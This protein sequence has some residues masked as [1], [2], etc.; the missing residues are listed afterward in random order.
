MNTTPRSTWDTTW[1]SEFFSSSSKTY[2]P[3]LNKVNPNDSQEAPH[4]VWLHF[5]F[6]ILHQ[7]EW[8]HLK[9]WRY[10]SAFTETSEYILVEHYRKN[11]DISFWYMYWCFKTILISTCW[12]TNLADSCWKIKKNRAKNLRTFGLSYVLTL[13]DSC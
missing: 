11:G 7:F 12:N 9:L 8:C 10:F 1:I 3:L 6:F 13:V 5:I 2:S 4:E